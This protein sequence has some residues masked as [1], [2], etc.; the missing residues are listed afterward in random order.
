MYTCLVQI[1]RKLAV[2]L[3]FNL[4]PMG[5]AVSDS[6]PKANDTS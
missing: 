1:M 2:P 4:N 6:T 3:C 5:H